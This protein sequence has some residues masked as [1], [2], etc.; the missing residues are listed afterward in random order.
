MVVASSSKNSSEKKALR[1]QLRKSR[2][3]IP[4]SQQL[5]TSQNICQHLYALPIFNRAN[6]VAIYSALDGEVDITLL[7][8]NKNKTWFLP[9]ISDGLRPWE[10]LGLCFQQ[11]SQDGIYRQNKYGIKEPIPNIHEEINPLMLD[12]VLL[13]LVGFDRQ[14]NRLGMGKGYY[15]RT[16]GLDKC[17]WRRPIMIGIAHAEQECSELD[18]QSWDIPLD[19]I[20]TELELITC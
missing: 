8:G 1:Q 10:T 17:R 3:A 15:D 5:D 12:I 14:G 11:A 4:E 7:S 13:P 6:T 19:F 2:N 9:L 20:V 16:F 18:A